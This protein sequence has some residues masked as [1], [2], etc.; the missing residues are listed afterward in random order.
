M[1]RSWR[2]AYA[3]AD[4]LPEAERY[5][6]TA[7]YW[8]SGPKPD[9]AKAVQAY[10][11]LLVIRPTNYAALNN[12]GLIYAQR[13]DFAKAEDLLRRAIAANPSV[14]LMYGN[15]MTYQA[16]QGKTAAMDSTFASAAIGQQSGSP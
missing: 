9:Q 12:L 1:D 13:R 4:R 3:H 6:A 7:S 16:E 5:L 8:N 2:E 11:S 10:E 15:L 14:P